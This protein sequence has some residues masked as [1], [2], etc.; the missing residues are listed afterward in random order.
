ML[1]DANA[2]LDQ[3][4]ASDDDRQYAEE[5]ADRVFEVSSEMGGS[6]LGD[7]DD[8]LIIKAKEIKQKLGE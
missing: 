7:V 2:T 5:L 8:Q 1:N 4:N 3:P 6:I